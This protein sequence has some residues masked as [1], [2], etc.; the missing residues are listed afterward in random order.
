MGALHGSPNPAALWAIRIEYYFWVWSSPSFRQSTK[1]FHK[2]VSPKDTSFSAAQ[3]SLLGLEMLA[4][5]GRL[6]R[7]CDTRKRLYA[8]LERGNRRKRGVPMDGSTTSSLI[9]SSGVF[10]GR[11]SLC[12]VIALLVFS[13]VLI[14]FSPTSCVEVSTTLAAFFY[15]R[16]VHGACNPV[17]FG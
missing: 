11:L 16:T 4:E 3:N 8:T 15:V 12:F 1:C 2:H 13:S 7:S 10:F 5:V 6:S 17:I 9:Q 14:H